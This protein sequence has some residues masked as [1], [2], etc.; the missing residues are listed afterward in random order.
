MLKLDRLTLI[1]SILVLF[2]YPALGQTEVDKYPN[3]LAIFNWDFSPAEE[4]YISGFRIYSAAGPQGPF[5]TLVATAAANLRTTQT[6]VQFFPGSLTVYYVVR[7]FRTEGIQTIE[8]AD[9]NVVEADMAVPTATGLR[10]K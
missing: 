4:P 10:V 6:H 3:D 8:G 9:S 1:L 2:N 7:P 5:T